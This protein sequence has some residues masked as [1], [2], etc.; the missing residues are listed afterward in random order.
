MI[1]KTRFTP[2]R[3]GSPRTRFR[4]LPGTPPRRPPGPVFTNL[5]NLR[6][7]PVFLDIEGTTGI[8]LRLPKRGTSQGVV[9]STTPVR[10]LPPVARRLPRTVLCFCNTTRSFWHRRRRRSFKG[11]A[12]QPH[13]HP[14][15]IQAHVC[16]VSPPPPASLIII[17]L[18]LA[19]CASGTSHGFN[20]EIHREDRF[21][22]GL[23]PHRRSRSVNASRPTPQLWR[24]L[25]DDA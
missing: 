4:P 23:C 14:E 19:L 13:R 12:R 15:L 21:T 8:L 20:P 9:P 1:P 17:T 6:G 7:S 2:R 25:I 16:T 5:D 24:F 18:R 10:W 22:P 3:E 11:T